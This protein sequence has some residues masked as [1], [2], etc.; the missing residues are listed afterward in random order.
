[1]CFLLGLPIAY[2]ESLCKFEKDAPFPDSHSPEPQSKTGGQSTG[3]TSAPANPSSGCLCGTT[4]P[5]RHGALFLPS[6]LE[7]PLKLGRM[8]DRQQLEHPV[9]Y[10]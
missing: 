1:M 4:K 8:V 9:V 10:N 6:L 3:Q 7:S 2:K 5:A